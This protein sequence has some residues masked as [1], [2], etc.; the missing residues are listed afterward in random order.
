MNRFALRTR[1]IQLRALPISTR[2]TVAVASLP[3][4]GY[5]TSSPKEAEDAS[6]QSGGSR[7]KDAVE[8]RAQV[9]MGENP[10][11][12]R[13]AKGG[14]PG[15]TG[16]GEPLASS[17]NAPPRPKIN[18][19]SMPGEGKNNLS[20]EQQEEVDEHNKDFEKKHDRAS[21]AGDDKVDKAFWKGRGG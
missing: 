5:A 1:G 4:R 6:A 18:N 11:E 9:E 20:K 16:G 12:D 3:I 21:P 15:R 14:A 13:L 7:S 17:E 8:E 19:A 2:A 10:T